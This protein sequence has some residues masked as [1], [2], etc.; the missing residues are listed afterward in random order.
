MYTCTCVPKVANPLPRSIIIIVAS[1][2]FC[3]VLVFPRLI[4]PAAEQPAVIWLC[5]D[6]D[7]FKFAANN[8]VKSHTPLKKTLI[9]AIQYYV[10]IIT[11]IVSN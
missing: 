4:Q 1:S 9:E 7:I 3:L 10:S 8:F 2:C 11:D 6:E 5:A